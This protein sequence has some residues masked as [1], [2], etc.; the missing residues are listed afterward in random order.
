MQPSC[1]ACGRPIPVE[2]V[3]VATDVA[4]CTACGQVFRASDIV[5][6]RLRDEELEPPPGCRIAFESVT[7]TEGAL[8]VP[9]VGPRLADA[10]PV[11]FATFWVGFMALWTF[12][13]SRASVFFA[14][15][16]IPFWLVG[17]AMWRGIVVAWTETQTISFD[18]R[19]VTVVRCGPVFTRRK[20]I[21]FAEITGIG[22]AMVMPSDPITAAR[23]FRRLTHMRGVRGI[24]VHVAEIRRG[25]RRTTFAEQ[26][27]ED[28][29]AWAVRVLV[30]IVEG[31]TGRRVGG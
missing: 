30:A 9:R 20:A 14:L 31:R 7:A 17:L 13:A 27:S 19:E 3:N 11:L 2:D 16:S 4:R 12:G 29:L 23:H 8:H 21:P 1:P 28:E 18:D 5:G 25:H 15:F 26:M 24:G 10:F 6:V 22:M